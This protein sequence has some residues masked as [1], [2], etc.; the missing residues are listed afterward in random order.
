MNSDKIHRSRSPEDDIWERKKGAIIESRTVGDH[1]GFLVAST[2]SSPLYAMSLITH[3][4][5]F[6]SLPLAISQLNLP[7]VLKCGQSFRW[8]RLDL[9]P[10]PP[11]PTPSLLP[12]CEWRLTLPD[13]LVCLRQTPTHLFYRS[14]PATKDEAPALAWLNDYFQ[15]DVDLH[16]LYDDWSLRDPV[17]R[18]F[19]DRFS[20]IRILRQDPWENLVSCVSI[21][22]IP[23]IH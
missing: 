3:I 19:R 1:H 14:L 13:R 9:D 2:F 10:P 17:F 16:S 8:S 7:A 6:Q 21:L 5:G 4:P 15:L 23:H 18:S 20:G 12:D 22:F 11:Q